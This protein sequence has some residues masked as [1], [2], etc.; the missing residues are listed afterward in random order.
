M[1]FKYSK[2]SKAK[3]PN[4]ENTFLVRILKPYEI[5]RNGIFSVISYDVLVQYALCHKQQ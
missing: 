1:I 3:L 2:L 4:I 5:K